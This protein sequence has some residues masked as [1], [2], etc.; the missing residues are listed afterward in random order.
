MMFELARRRTLQLPEGI[1]A[2]RY[3]LR[4]VKP[5]IVH[6]GLGGFHRS[7]FAR[8]THDLMEIAPEALSWGIIGAGLRSSD[9]PLLRALA[10]Q[11][12]LYTLVE[13]DA[14]GERRSVIGSIV[15]VIDASENAAALLARIARPETRIVSITVSE[16]GYH[17]DAATKA[18]DLASDAIRRDVSTP[19][20]PKTMPGIL[21]EAFRL[22][23]DAGLPAFTA[24]SC[25]NI[26]HNGKV[27]RGA[28]LA[29]AG[30]TDPELAVW[31]AGH[32]TFPSS[33]VD[34]I[35]PVPTREAIERFAAKTGLADKA[36]V[37]S[38]A[39]R[40]WVIEDDF[41][42]GRPD[43]SQ[44]GAQFVKD[45]SPYEA[46][47]L[48]LLNASHLAIA[49]LGA[50]SGYETVEETMA[51]PAIRR[52]MARLM[53]EET[54]PLLAPVPGIDLAQYKATL[55]ARFANPAIRDTVRR[56]NTD[57]PINLLL[58][59]L[60]DALATNAPLDLL[61]LGLAAWC[62]RT[63][64]ELA[65]GK[66]IAGANANPDLQKFRAVDALAL[67]SVGSLFGDLGRNTRLSTSVRSWLD[68][69]A[70]H[71]ASAALTQAFPGSG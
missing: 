22:R 33:M 40:Q 20:A 8:Y 59:P 52:Y 41:A 11:D 31:I 62:R 6:I 29:L 36:T 2:P 13:R 12:G 32:A 38:E 69:F 9:V 42:C 15:G 16:A 19:R 24:L 43:W 46:M 5:G 1:A 58:D 50:L 55:I 21:V 53:D 10:H 67:L 26:Q 68:R 49:G 14:S 28:V 34:R 54:G 23:R 44:A 4:A 35:T 61:A 39:F 45:V 27:L 51:D 3:D 64:D 30:R 70:A 71:G 25:D 37:F 65:A 18:L 17:L 60:R 56:I 7:H 63:A 66:A 47:K 48:R 57:A